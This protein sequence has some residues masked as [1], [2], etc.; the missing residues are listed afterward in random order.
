MKYFKCQVGFEPDTIEKINE[1][2][3]D[4]NIKTFSKS[5]RVLVDKG[6]EYLM[7]E[8]YLKQYDEKLKTTNAKLNYT[9]T[10]IKQL[11]SDLELEY[12]TNIKKNPELKKIDSNIFRSNYDK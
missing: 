4:N 5:V 7:L 6:L 3:I 2:A 10:L 11:Y 8:K 9:N 1:F 12:H